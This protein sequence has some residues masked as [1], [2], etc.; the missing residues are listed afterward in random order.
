MEGY[1]S[2]TYIQWCFI[3]SFS[4]YISLV[5]Y[6]MTRDS[7]EFK[8]RKTVRDS[9][10]KKASLGEILKCKSGFEMYITKLHTTILICTV[11]YFVEI[12]GWIANIIAPSAKR[13]KRARGRKRP[14]GKRNCHH[15]KPRR[16]RRRLHC[17]PRRCIYGGRK[18]G[19]ILRFILTL[20]WL[21]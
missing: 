7:M 8:K 6:V 11:Y 17:A 18:H 20:A 3:F 5:S 9:L 2:L 10:Q 21:N 4:L 13:R 1:G 19:S 16:H 14:L 15:T 12:T